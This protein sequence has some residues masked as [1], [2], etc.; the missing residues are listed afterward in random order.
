MTAHAEIYGFGGHIGINVDALDNGESRLSLELQDHHR[1]FFGIV[2][3]GV[4]LTMLDQT[5]GAA[6]RSTRAP[7]GP[8]GSVTVDLQTVFVAPAKGDT[9]HAF[10]TCLRSGRSIAHCTAR[11]EDD[12][13]TL[14]VTA[15][16]VFKLIH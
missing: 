15:T 14:V 6:L 8:Q 16:G 13:G 11:I 9:L 4:L 1:N 12:E 10:G 3:G 7:G 2:H 5:C